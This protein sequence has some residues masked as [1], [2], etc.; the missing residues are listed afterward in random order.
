MNTNH[1]SA[2]AK[3]PAVTTT[4]LFLTLSCALT[5][6]QAQQTNASPTAAPTTI[7]LQDAL[8][9]AQKNEPQYRNALT[10]YGV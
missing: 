10:Q 1:R 9:R 3:F 7:T 4:V 5:Q 8:G 6:G 2:F